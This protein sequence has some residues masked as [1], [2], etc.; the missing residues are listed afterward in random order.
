VPENICRRRIG[1][2]RP[3]KSGTRRERERVEDVLIVI[4]E[5]ELRLRKMGNGS[6]RKGSVTE[7][8]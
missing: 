6:V 3:L 5:C 7:Q 2:N 1:I 8:S 4:V